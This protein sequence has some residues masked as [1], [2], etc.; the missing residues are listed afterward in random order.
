[1]CNKYLLDFIQSDTLLIIINNYHHFTDSLVRTG[2]N[3]VYTASSPISLLKDDKIAV[4]SV[5]GLQMQFIHFGQLF[6]NITNNC[7]ENCNFTC[8]SVVS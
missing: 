6:T 8:Q 4:A 7:G 1:M 2:Q 5:V 3:F